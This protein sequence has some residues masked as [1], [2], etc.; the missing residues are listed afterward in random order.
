MRD[1]PKVFHGLSG[2]QFIALAMAVLGWVML[3]QRTKTMLASKKL[4]VQD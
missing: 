1:T 4:I 2:Y 3:R